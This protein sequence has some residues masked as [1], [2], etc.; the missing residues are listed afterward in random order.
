MEATTSAL[1]L[2][3]L[4]EPVHVTRSPGLGHTYRMPSRPASRAISEH[5][6]FNGVLIYGYLEDPH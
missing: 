2:P 3:L 1:L 6:S 4:G 5:A